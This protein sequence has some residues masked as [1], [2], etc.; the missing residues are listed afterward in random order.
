MG[1]EQYENFIQTDAAINPGNSGGALVNTRG[2]L[3]G[4]NTAIFSRTGG[5]MGIGFA[6]P[7]NMAKGVME[8][9][10]KTG[11]VVR[12]YLGVSIQDLSPKIAKQFGLDKAHGA[13]VGDVVGGSPAE[14]A[15]IQA[16]DVITRFDG[17]AIENS[18]ML[19]NRV[20][21]TPV[22]QSAELEVVRDKKPLTLK[23][24]VTE[25]PKDMSAAGESVKS[26][27]QGTALA[28]L[29]VRNLTRETAQ[30]LN[31]PRGT[32]G[33]VV[34]EVASG[35]T[36]EEAGLRAGDVIIE[37]NRKPVRNIDD[38]RRLSSALGED[39]AALLRI[40]RQGRRLFVAI[41]P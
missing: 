33:V 6:I 16:G 39:E 5:Y 10:V 36:A 15:G 29:E 14:K 25:Q 9:L 7:S 21:E 4:I 28:G 23:V 3:V 11:K 18:S 2:E 12:G 13:L 24:K 35:S 1:I 26:A 32:Q 30:E 37:L 38:F 20:A 31:L 22:G 17:K 41:N 27:G 8:S 34:A 19:R 40:V